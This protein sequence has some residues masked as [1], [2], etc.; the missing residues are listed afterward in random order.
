MGD[1]AQYIRS[2]E[3]KMKC[4]GNAMHGVDIRSKFHPIR[5]TGRCMGFS[6]M[7][8][9]N[10]LKHQPYYNGIGSFLYAFVTSSFRP[11]TDSI[12]HSCG[13]GELLNESKCRRVIVVPIEINR[14]N[15]LLPYEALALVMAMQ[16]AIA[17]SPHNAFNAQKFIKCI[18]MSMVWCKNE[19]SW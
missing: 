5:P 6:W 14:I 11:F 8:T 3:L 1:T 13:Y 18:M 19:G 12:Y 2:G 4:I 9:N 10:R 16:L 17:C 15:V 7:L